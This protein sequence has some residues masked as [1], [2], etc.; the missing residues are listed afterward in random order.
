MK[1]D[2]VKNKLAELATRNTELE[3]ELLANRKQAELLVKSVL[4]VKYPTGNVRDIDQVFDDSTLELKIMGLKLETIYGWDTPVEIRFCI[5]NK[6]FISKFNFEKLTANVS[7]ATY[8][9]AEEFV[10]K[11]LEELGIPVNWDGESL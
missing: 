2:D 6:E 9:H 8:S 10:K 5:K 11:R 7:H 1:I 4:K 3:K